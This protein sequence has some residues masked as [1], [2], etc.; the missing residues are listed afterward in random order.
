MSDG[1]FFS[2]QL[3]S[4]TY[5]NIVDLMVKVNYEMFPLR[6]RDVSCLFQ[7]SVFIFPRLEIKIIEVCL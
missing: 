4:A 5:S 6:G 7:P 1:R 3:R 2:L